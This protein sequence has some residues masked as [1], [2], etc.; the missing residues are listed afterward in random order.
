M[1]FLVWRME[2][3]ISG[4]GKEKQRKNIG[5]SLTFQPMTYDIYASALACLK[6]ISR[7]LNQNY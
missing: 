4:L 7:P 3:H 1:I 6:E 2:Y 5:S